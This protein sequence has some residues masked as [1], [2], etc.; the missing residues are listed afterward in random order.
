MV[1][2]FIPF[3]KTLRS[4]VAKL[5]IVDKHAEAL[6]ADERSMWVP[7]ESAMDALARAT[8]AIVSGSALVEGGIEQLLAAA[9]SAR[10]RIMAG[11]TTPMWPRPFFKRGVDILGGIRVRQG[12]QLLAIVGQ[13]GSGY[14]FEEAA[15]KSCV[16]RPAGSYTQETIT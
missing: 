3:I 6:R 2:A 9:A 5:W 15:E 13:G 4:R 11:P 7:P 16:I 8:V 10:I 14:F 1:G 12:E